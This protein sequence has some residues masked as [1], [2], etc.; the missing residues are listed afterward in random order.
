MGRKQKIF[1]GEEAS[2]M[3]DISYNL[4]YMLRDKG[5]S[6][7]KFAKMIGV[8]NYEIHSYIHVRKMPSDEML[9]RIANVLECTVDELTQEYDASMPNSDKD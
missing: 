3:L 5:L 7:N 1:V 8:T 6:V 9:Q 2:R 4:R